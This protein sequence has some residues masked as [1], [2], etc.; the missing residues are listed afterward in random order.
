MFSSND[1][2][3]S[4]AKGTLELSCFVQ[5]PETM[6]INSIFS[7]T[8]LR[9][10]NWPLPYIWQTR[11]LYDTTALI[12]SSTEHQ[13]RA[14]SDVARQVLSFGPAA[15]EMYECI[16]TRANYCIVFMH[17]DGDVKWERRRP[18]ICWF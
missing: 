15:V 12:I 17:V 18:E 14:C 11:A 5:S 7:A 9:I 8:F 10:R 2:K 16:S 4:V 6:A 3:H 13:G 1:N